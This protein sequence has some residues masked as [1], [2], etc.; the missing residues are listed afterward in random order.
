MYAYVPV[1]AQ[2]ANA[3]LVPVTEPSGQSPHPASWANGDPHS[4][5]E[6]LPSYP[7][8]TWIQR[9]RGSRFWLLLDLPPAVMS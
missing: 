9:H 6:F 1:P 3:C 5:A 8:A 7:G 2:K 4:P